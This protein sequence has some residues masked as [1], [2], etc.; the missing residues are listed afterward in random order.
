MLTCRASA[1]KPRV[2]TAAGGRRALVGAALGAPLL[3][4]RPREALAEE[5]PQN[6][7]ESWGKGRPCMPPPPN[8]EPRY[9][10]PPMQYDPAGEAMKRFQEKAAKAA[11]AEAAAAAAPAE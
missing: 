10:M 9:K 11:A 1:S 3:L 7:L 6:F 4:R 5:C 2:R 8:G